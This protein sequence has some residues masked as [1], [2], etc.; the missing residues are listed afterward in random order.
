[1]ASRQMVARQAKKVVPKQSPDKPKEAAP[2]APVHTEKADDRAKPAEQET[3]PTQASIASLPGVP[4]VAGGDVAQRQQTIGHTG[5]ETDGDRIRSY[6]ARLGKRLQASLVYPPEVRKNGVEGVS[7]IMFTITTSGAIKADSLRLQKSSGHPAMD[8]NALKS[9]LAG[10][11]FEKPPKELT[12]SIAVSFANDTAR[13]R[14][15]T[16]AR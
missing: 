4:S 14:N 7:T 16:S 3:G 1:M 8:T 9:A 13:T 6:V 5:Q 12:V 11:P 2:D 15:R 10:A